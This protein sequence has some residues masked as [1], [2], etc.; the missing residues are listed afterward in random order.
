MQLERQ[1]QTMP[2]CLFENK[3]CD[4]V[5]NFQNGGKKSIREV[6]S[7]IWKQ[8]WNWH[9]CCW[10][11]TL[12][13]ASPSVWWVLTGS[14]ISGQYCGRKKKICKRTMTLQI[15]LEAH[16]FQISMHVK[17]TWKVSLCINN[18]VTVIGP[19]LLIKKLCRNDII[20]LLRVLVKSCRY[21]FEKKNVSFFVLIMNRRMKS[22]D[23]WKSC[24]LLQPSIQMLMFPFKKWGSRTMTPATP[25]QICYLSNSTNTKLEKNNNLQHTDYTDK[26]QWHIFIIIIITI[27]AN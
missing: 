16:V 11:T 19:K 8:L 18:H 12:G 25:Q 3:S 24:T 7:K 5:H 27:F 9:T 15:Y 21:F 20:K 13:S 6:L 14:V 23:C 2:P 22:C 4:P 1:L 17:L 26:T 10:W